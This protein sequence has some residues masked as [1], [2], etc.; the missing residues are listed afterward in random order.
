MNEV[1]ESG[2]LK[3]RPFGGVMI[4]I[5]NDLRR[6]TETVFCSSRYAIIR[7]ANLL[8]INV[9][10]PCNGTSNRLI[11][12]Q[13]LLAEIWSWC[14]QF[15]CCHYVFAGDFNANIDGSDTI[16]NLLYTIMDRENRNNFYGNIFPRKS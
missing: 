13:D 5:K 12:C 10:L 3:G 2:M 9:Y 15:P 7:V 1:I 11:I 6:L 4:M 16:S 8:F 14:E